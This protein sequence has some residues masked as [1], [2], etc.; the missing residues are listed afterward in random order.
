MSGHD[1]A[2]PAHHTG[3]IE[4][5]EE[6]VARAGH[7]ILHTAEIAFALPEPATSRWH[8]AGVGPRGERIFNVVSGIVLTLFAMGWTWSIAMAR[9]GEFGGDV[10]DA[11][12]SISAALTD[13]DAPTAAFMTDAMLAALT[14]LRGTSG[15]LRATVQQPGE[16][17]A[18]D[19]VADTTS[20]AIRVAAGADT[21][22]VVAPERA[23]I[24]NIL[25]KV[26]AALQPVTDFNVI[27][28]HPFEE[29]QRGRV[30]GYFIGNWPGERSRSVRRGYAHPSGFIEVTPQNRD[31]QVSDHFRLRDFLTHDQP[32]V[33]PKYL[34]L[35]M[36]LVD[37]L[38]LILSDLS[39]RGYDVSGVTVMSGFRTPRYNVNGGDPRGRAALSRHMYGDASD[40]FIDSDHDG[41]M[42][43]LNHDRR[44]NIRDAQVILAAVDRVEREHPELLGGAGVYV[45]SGGHGPFIHI[46]T[47]GFRA[48]WV[49]TGDD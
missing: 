16:P 33:W 45:A 8:R 41:V 39:S 5:V 42:D 13:P 46:D 35:E 10:T 47:R 15:K 25:V 40:I 19:T 14:P 24:W 2:R 1:P 18:V 6:A 11:T 37:K 21:G 31:L 17:V 43:D 20:T 30:G 9:S 4:V 32:N 49:G 44:V 48:R 12:A 27:T 36:K 23:G 29:K 22:S 26:G 38:E 28:M 7:A 3:A 34:V